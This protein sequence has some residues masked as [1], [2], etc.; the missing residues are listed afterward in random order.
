MEKFNGD[1]KKN[2][3]IKTIPTATPDKIAENINV[4]QRV[5]CSKDICVYFFV[6]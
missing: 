3:Y 6:C 5:G 2:V 4:P 1:P